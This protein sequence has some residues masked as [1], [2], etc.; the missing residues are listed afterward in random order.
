MNVVTAN[1]D[2]LTLDTI[3]ASMSSIVIAVIFVLLP[4]GSV[5]GESRA[6]TQYF[7]VQ[8]PDSWVYKQDFAANDSLLLVPSELTGLV[9]D[10]ASKSL[11]NLA[12]KGVLIEFGRDLDYRPTNNSLEKY[13]RYFL[14]SAQQN[15]DPEF[16]NATLGGE[17]ATKILING[18]EVGKYNPM[19]NIT[20]SIN[21]I[22]YLVVHH[23]QPYYLYYIANENNYIKY[24]NDF[25]QIVSN[26][27]VTK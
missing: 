24:L 19:K 1:G 5:Y 3:T 20:G 10:D 16:G 14:N 2:L 4:V 12:E 17:R 6:E 15:Y 23:N 9:D 22:A 7:S 18:T 27:R 25:E 8:L 26:F 11:L 13:S 21:S